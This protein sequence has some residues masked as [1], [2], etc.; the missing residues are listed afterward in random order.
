LSTPESPISYAKI[1]NPVTHFPS[2]EITVDQNPIGTLN[3]QVAARWTAVFVGR[4]RKPKRKNLTHAG[5]TPLGKPF[6]DTSLSTPTT[7]G[8]PHRPNVAVSG[9]D[10]LTA[11]WRTPSPTPTDN[12][13]NSCQGSDTNLPGSPTTAPRTATST[14]TPQATSCLHPSRQR[15]HHGPEM[16]TPKPGVV[17]NL[18]LWVALPSVYH[19]R[20][21]RQLQQQPR[22]TPAAARVQLG[23]NPEVVCIKAPPVDSVPLPGL[24]V[25]Q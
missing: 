18:C 22:A 14:T 13:P 3:Q 25:R 10:V 19:M 20:R 1:Y 6:G 9:T 16:L 15:R 8:H 4:D 23:K 2:P 21:D 7:V 17:S 24:D 12:H 5:S 11:G